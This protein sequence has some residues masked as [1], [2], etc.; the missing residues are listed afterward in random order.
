MKAALD[1]AQL[2]D[3][4]KGLMVERSEEKGEKD[5]DRPQMAGQS[6]T[7]AD[8]V[9]PDLAT[10]AN[11]VR[12]ADL[13]GLLEKPGLARR[14]SFFLE[15]IFQRLAADWRRDG[16]EQNARFLWLVAS[17]A[18]G[19]ASYF[20]LPDEPSL[21]FLLTATL[22][23][24]VVALQRALR[25]RRV[26][27]LLVVGM[28]IFGCTAAAFQSQFFTTPVLAEARS[29]SIVGRI[30]RVE[31]RSSGDER[32]TLA[33]ESI[34]RLAAQQ[35][36]HKLLL[37]RK[38]VGGAY[39]AGERVQIYARLVPLQ[40]PAYPGG[41]DYGRYLWSRSIGAQGYMGRRVERQPSVEREGLV[42]LWQQ[43]GVLVEQM[44]SAVAGYIGARMEGEA[45]GL[46]IALSVGKRDRL[47]EEVET[48]LRRS[49]LAHILAISGLH[50]GLIAM[51]VFWGMRS[52]LSS[53][54]HLA[55]TYPIKEWA[56]GVA[57]AAAAFYLVLSGASVA[58]IRAFLMTAIFLLAIMAG[59]SALTM[60]NLALAL[61]V[62]VLMQPYGVIEAGMQMSFAATAALIATYDRVTRMRRSSAGREEAL[63]KRGGLAATSALGPLLHV[64]QGAAK[65]IIGIGLTSLI[66]SF[67]VLPF[68]VAHFQQMAP[69][70][71]IANLLVMPI[72]SL[73]VM[74][75]GL[76]SF[77]LAPLGLQSLPLQGVQWG[78]EQVIALSG[79]VSS[80][81]DPSM[82]VV[83]AGGQFLLPAVLALMLFAIHRRTMALLALIPAAAAL[84]LW[85]GGSLGDMWISETGRRMA[86][87]GVDQR[88]QLIGSNR[89][90]LDFSALLRADGDVRAALNE[91]T[92]GGAKGLLRTESSHQ[93]WACDQHACVMAGLRTASGPKTN[94]SAALVKHPGAF[95]EECARRDIIISKL[96]IPSTCI[97]PKL[98]M[99]R[100]ELEANGSVLV[101]FAHKSQSPPNSA[102]SGD[103]ANRSREW[104]LSM[105]SAMPKGRRP[106]HRE[107]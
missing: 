20:N 21:T 38:S 36:P 45:A 57:L 23:L 66:A 63:A 31:R 44:R 91:G 60:H 19:A 87:R 3:R 59:R 55:L 4:V 81:S 82:V 56:A 70:G 89:M 79:L 93:P 16:E 5:A 100:Q 24:A 101:T 2:D 34:E 85:W 28:G 69:L 40:R 73:V 1:L 32:W 72:I 15:A 105:Q 14:V 99:G 26:F 94:L 84:M 6:G 12:V 58:T 67:A 41:F 43:G 68:S 83:R 92:G 27:L 9:R 29:A 10:D 46:A 54:P 42:G 97:A 50:M 47:T 8:L 106:W 48:N 35:T 11:Q 86:V 51:A 62:L 53:L 74:P 25:G 77:V 33:V 22:G 49:G 104:A 7:F 76:V 71:L 90:V 107:P 39:R 95:D 98:T 30:E 78:L 18:L 75:L 17:L 13:E 65:W 102:Q 103:I 88:W 96:P 80:H 52:V 61:L 37:V 64:S